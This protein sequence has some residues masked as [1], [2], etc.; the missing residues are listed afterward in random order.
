MIG[1]GDR[2]ALEAAS[3]S[4]EKNHGQGVLVVQKDREFKDVAV[5]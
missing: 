2:L 1:F 5:F 3:E 4:N